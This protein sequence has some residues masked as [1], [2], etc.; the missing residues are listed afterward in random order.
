LRSAS[1]KTKNRKIEKYH[2]VVYP[3]PACPERSRRAG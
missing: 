2:A 1:A 3:E